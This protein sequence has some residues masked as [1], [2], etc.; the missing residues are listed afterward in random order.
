M[1]LSPTEAHARLL[2]CLPWDVFWLLAAKQRGAEGALS[3]LQ[4]ANSLL[5]LTGERIVGGFNQL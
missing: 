4:T 2:R 3:P 5:H 1:E